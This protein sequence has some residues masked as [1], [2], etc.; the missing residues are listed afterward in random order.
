[1]INDASSNPKE[2]EF[3]AW[4]TSLDQRK[5][6][7]P[8][9]PSFLSLMAPNHQLQILQAESLHKSLEFRQLCL[10]RTEFSLQS[11]LRV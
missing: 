7:A 2:N 1:M 10:H 9:V 5:H 8:E 11:C 6:M 4:L 3:E